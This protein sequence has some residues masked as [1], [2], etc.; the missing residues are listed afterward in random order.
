MK[1]FIVCG[2]QIM[3]KCSATS[4]YLAIPTSVL[5]VGVLLTAISHTHWKTSMQ[6]CMACIST[7]S[8]CRQPH[9]APLEEELDQPDC[10]NLLPG[11]W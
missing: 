9:L 8:V 6:R 2:E 3:F 1:I 7:V 5:S 11:V 10:V 4:D